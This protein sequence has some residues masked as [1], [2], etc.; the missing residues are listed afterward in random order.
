[1]S[2]AANT[3]AVTT[4]HIIEAT[5]MGKH[6]IVHVDAEWIAADG[7]RKSHRTTFRSLCEARNWVKWS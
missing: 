7:R 4:Y 1:M 2:N 6:P 3:A 5:S